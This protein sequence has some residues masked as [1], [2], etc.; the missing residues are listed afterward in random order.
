MIVKILKTKVMIFGSKKSSNQQHNF[1]FNYQVVEVT[2]QYKYLGV[3]FTS[4]SCLFNKHLDG[5]FSSAL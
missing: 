1:Y 3:I 4:E 5:S 2:K